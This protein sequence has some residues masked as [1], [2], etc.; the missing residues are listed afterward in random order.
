M[1]KI[2][3]KIILVISLIM[4]ILLFII[5]G[6]TYAYFSD[7]FILDYLNKSN[8]KI[9]LDKKVFKTER[10]VDNTY[11]IKI[12]NNDKYPVFVRVKLFY[13][14]GV[15]IQTPNI[16]NTGWSL[17]QDGYY[18]YDSPISVVEAKYTNELPIKI[19]SSNDFNIIS[20][21]EYTDATY[22]LTGVASANWNR[23]LVDVDN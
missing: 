19:S 10:I 13:G 20:V 18:Y 16:S 11:Y 8:M 23:V 15:S 5:I 1:K 2:N 4:F 12:G 3:K 22:S 6:N 9:N 7:Y 14:N 17:N 21:F